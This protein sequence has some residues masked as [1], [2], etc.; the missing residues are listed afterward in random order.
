MSDELTGW[1]V[2]VS[3][4]AGE[5]IFMIAEPTQVKALQLAKD[6]IEMREGDDITLGMSVSAAELH[7]A[8]MKRG[9]VKER[10]TR[11]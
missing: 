2:Q 1:I 4:A 10:A 8:A 5:R 11:A 3:G 9:D 7:R 6:T